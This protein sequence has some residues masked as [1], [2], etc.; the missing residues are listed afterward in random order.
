M[1][2]QT[3]LYSL[4]PEQFKPPELWDCMNSCANC[5]KYMGHFPMGGKRCEYGM[6]MDGTSGKDIYQEVDETSV[7]HFYCKYFKLED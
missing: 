4:F 3:D 7:V 1:T 5:G 2:G 6:H